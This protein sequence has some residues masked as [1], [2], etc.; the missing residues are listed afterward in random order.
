MAAMHIDGYER[1]GASLKSHAAFSIS[2]FFIA[3]SSAAEHFAI[4]RR[5]G[6]LAFEGPRHFLGGFSL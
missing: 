5:A 4:D 2:T 3:Q 1:C 6:W